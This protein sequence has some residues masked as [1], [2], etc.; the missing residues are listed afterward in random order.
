MISKYQVNKQLAVGAN[1]ELLM[2]NPLLMAV[3]VFDSCEALHDAY[4]SPIGRELTK[5]AEAT[6]A[7]TRIYRIDATVQL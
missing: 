1:T 3:L 7:N 6:I 4:R 5:S 2:H